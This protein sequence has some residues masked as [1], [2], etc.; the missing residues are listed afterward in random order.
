MLIKLI[1]KFYFCR[2]SSNNNLYFSNFELVKS[3]LISNFPFCPWSKCETSATNF[4][5]CIYTRSNTEGNFWRYQGEFIINYP[6]NLCPVH[7]VAR[8]EYPYCSSSKIW[9]R[10]LKRNNV[11]NIEFGRKQKTIIQTKKDFQ[12]IFVHKTRR[13]KTSPCETPFADQFIFWWYL[14]L[15]KF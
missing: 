9:K 7:T 1:Q 11:L 12:L 6:D 10:I 14:V 8:Q 15:V 5:V 3:V 2:I 4:V 13:L